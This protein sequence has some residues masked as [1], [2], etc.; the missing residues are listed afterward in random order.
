V[1]GTLSVADRAVVPANAPLMTVVDLSQLEVEL[2]VPE[3]YADD[4]GIG[5]NVEVRIGAIAATGQLSA[6]SPEVVKNHVLVRVRFAGEQPAGLRQSQRVTARILIE[7]RPD[8]LM[9][10]RGP[11]VEAHGGRHA[12]VVEDGV[13]V[14]RPIRVGATSVSSIEILE[15]LRAGQRVVIA[16][17][18]TFEDAAT[19]RIND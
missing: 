15:G 14:R 11:F 3:T 4:L 9:V 10:A 16:G 12:Y 13:A 1:V 7:E 5:M 17:S 6:L 8:V 19:V 18:E 2:E